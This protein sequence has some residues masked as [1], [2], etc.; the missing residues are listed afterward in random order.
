MMNSDHMNDLLGEL[1]KPF[2]PSRITWRPGALTSKKDKALALAYADLRAYQNRLDEVCGMDWSVSY[3][4]WRD[5]IICH[6]TIQGITRSSTGEP[7]SDSER[8]EIA[9]TTAE[10]QAFKRACAMFGLGR[11]LYNLPSLWVEYD[12]PNQRFTEKAKAR[13]Q[14]L[15][16]Q[17]YQRFLDGQPASPLMAE[18]DE[19]PEDG[20]V[21]G[22]SDA[23]AAPAQTNET[24]LPAPATKTPESKAAKRVAETATKR[25]EEVVSTAVITANG[26]QP[27]GPVAMQSRA[28]VT[29]AQP[30]ATLERVGESSGTAPDPLSPLHNKLDELGKELYGEQWA[31]VRAHNIKRLVGEENDGSGSLSQAQIQTLINGLKKLKQQRQAA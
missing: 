14:G 6:L 23:A 31:H 15:I 3:T 9:G 13:L 22:P 19:A 27:E 21:A 24:P 11:Y 10:A 2:H 7:D 29:N 12:A 16:A 18:Y 17:H 30:V 28:K 25:V 1:S 8:S 4:P 5:R 26:T 20:Q